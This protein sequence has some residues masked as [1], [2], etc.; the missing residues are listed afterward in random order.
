M[1]LTRRFSALRQENDFLR[2]V[3]SLA[4]PVALQSLLNT[5]INLV[6]TIMIGTLQE[7]TIAAVG[8]ANKVFFVMMLLL[9][10]IAGGSSVLAAQYWGK[11]DVP[12]IR[13]TLGMSLTLGVSASML[14][15][16]PSMLCPQLVMYIFTNDASVAEIGAS[17][18]RIVAFSYP[19]TA[20]SNAFIATL[21]SVN[22]VRIPLLVSVSSIFVNVFFNYG[23]IFGKMGMPC[24][25]VEGAALAT[26]IARIIEC[27]VLLAIVYFT[28]SPAAARIREM[29]RFSKRFVRLY[30]KTAVPVI[31]NE[32]IWGLGVTIYSLVYGRMPPEATSAITISQT[33]EQIIVVLCHG[34][35]AATVVILG[36]EMGAGNLKKAERYASHFMFLQLFGGLAM[37]VITLLCS[38]P[39]PFLFDISEQTTHYVRQC[40]WVFACYTPFKMFNYVNIVG[41]LRSGGDTVAAMLLDAGGV[42]MLGIPLAF[43]GG[44]WLKLPIYVV[45]A[46]ALFEEVA[47]ALVGFWRYRQKKWLRTL[48][49]TKPPVS[50]GTD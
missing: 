6:D 15:A 36:N 47:K 26:L 11:Q 38:Y 31:I 5:V 4:I 45:Y 22:Q 16:L 33:V 49:Q 35:G 2:K 14:F 18:L 9:L 40:L 7:T 32:F 46:M 13:R 24:M 29:F 34:M 37:A 3:A 44:L 42:W 23:L 41:V 17:Y 21:R 8:L 30:I 25:G 19:L 27:A 12:N 43:I 28:R 1:F 48:I 10:G 39:V 20:I 50:D